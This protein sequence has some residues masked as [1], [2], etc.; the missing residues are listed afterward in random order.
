MSYKL[1]NKINF[2][3][4]SLLLISFIFQCEKS[5]HKIQMSPVADFE[6]SLNFIG[7]IKTRTTFEIES[8]N[9][10]L[11]CETLDRD[12]TDYEK[13]KEF[14]S[15]LGIKK[16][17]L[18]AGWAKTEKTKGEYIEEPVYVDI[19]SGNVYK[20]PDSNWS[21]NDKKLTISKLPVYDA[22]IVIADKSIIKLQ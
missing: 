3:I 9:W 17:R 16:L 4:M 14:L 19:L 7:K 1:K 8:S 11:G 5:T 20:I 22:P 12:M 2:P 21:K 18:Q 15:L 13:Y 6:S 10:I